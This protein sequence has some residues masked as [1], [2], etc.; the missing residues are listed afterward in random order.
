MEKMKYFIFAMLLLLFTS[1][2]GT[3]KPEPGQV[4]FSTAEE[5]STALVDAIKKNDTARLMEIFGPQGKSIVF[6]GD[7][8][9]DNDSRLWFI[10]KADE[11]T[12]VVKSDVVGIE[13]GNDK[14]P[15]PVPIVKYDGKWF[16]H[17]SA[18]LDEMQ[19][20]RIGRNELNAI[21]VCRELVAA[22]DEFARLKAT[23]GAGEY[24]V[25]FISEKGKFNG[26]YWDAAESVRKSPIGARIVLA[27]HESPRDKS[28]PFHG[29]YYKI[30]ISQGPDA[31]G[32]AKSYISNGKMTRGFAIA[33]YPAE[34]GV[35]GIKSF[36]VAKNGVVFEKDMGKDTAELLPA[37]T[38]FNPDDTWTPA[39][40]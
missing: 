36:M 32:G 2:C 8:K 7:A 4:V 3:V 26:L 6:S 31:P 24:A 9:Y 25:R 22:Q 39:R 27:S 5:A 15:F 30:L 18:G 1:G 10:K 37:M 13:V 33:A 38:K 20:R 16:F 12:A 29:Y 17:T 14:W 28:R 19:N 40:D 11:K 21:K 34:Y 23:E 35:S